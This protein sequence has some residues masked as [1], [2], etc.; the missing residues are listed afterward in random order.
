M[1]RRLALLLCALVVAPAPARAMMNS[2]IWAHSLRVLSP[3]AGKT[4][5]RFARDV[6][7]ETELSDGYYF[8][9]LAVYDRRDSATMEWIGSGLDA[10]TRAAEARAATSYLELDALARSEAQSAVPEFATRI[11][12]EVGECLAANPQLRHRLGR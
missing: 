6:L 3:E 7:G 11:A 9:C 10:L 1:K 5:L 2:E 4:L 12:R 8:D